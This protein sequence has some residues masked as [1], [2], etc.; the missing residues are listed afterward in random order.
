M[1]Q[2]SNQIKKLREENQQLKQSQNQKAI[3]ELEKLKVELVNKVSPVNLSYTDYVQ[4]VFTRLNNQIKELKENNN[5][6]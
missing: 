3:E 1:E 6:N 5:E 2:Q 4:E